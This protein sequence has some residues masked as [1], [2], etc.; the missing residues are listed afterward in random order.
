MGRYYTIK[1]Y[2]NSSDREEDKFEYENK[3]WFGIVNTGV[4]GEFG[5]ESTDYYY[6]S[7]R[8]DYF[9][10][11][12][13]A[14]LTDEEISNLN[15]IPSFCST[16]YYIDDRKRFMEADLEGNLTFYETNFNFNCLF[17][18]I[19]ELRNSDLKIRIDFNELIEK[20]KS[21]TLTFK[22]A[23]NIEMIMHDIASVHHKKLI[24]SNSVSDM[25]IEDNAITLG[26]G[27][28]I[29][30]LLFEYDCVTIDENY[31]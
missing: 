27:L 23:E 16:Y 17:E 12:D 18:A 7:E 21:K 10:E 15:D 19:K 13:M 20:L 29:A 8:D 5:N 24:S 14:E 4:A 30:S 3:L 9:S 2:N 26:Y 28:M 6:V 22:E 31:C 1:A 11:Y 25:H